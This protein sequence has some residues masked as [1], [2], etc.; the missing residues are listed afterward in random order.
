MEA[1]T[2]RVP[3]AV[4]RSDNGRYDICYCN[5]GTVWQ[6]DTQSGNWSERAKPLPGSAAARGAMI[7]EK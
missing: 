2:Y 6:L 5:D 4:F 3:V 7:P 1:P